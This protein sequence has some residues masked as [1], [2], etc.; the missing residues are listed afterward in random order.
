MVTEHYNHSRRLFILKVI[1]QILKHLIGL[2]DQIDIQ[3]RLG[4]IDF[5]VLHCDIHIQIPGVG[6]KITTV[7]LDRHV[8]GKE[9]HIR[10]LLVLVELRDDPLRQRV[11][12]DIAA[13]VLRLRKIV[14]GV[15]GIKSN[16]RVD[17][18]SPVV[19]PAI[20]M[21]RQRLIALAFQLRRDGRQVSA[22]KQVE[23]D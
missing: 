11:V 12:R 5:R 23:T 4:L 17:Q 19:R 18:I 1:H 16:L 21:H 10:V 9:R 2:P 8:V 3:S 15:K 7:I 20:R 6:C 14:T 22:H 13:N